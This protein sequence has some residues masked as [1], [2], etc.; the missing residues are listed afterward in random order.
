[1]RVKLIILIL[2][3]SATGAAYSQ[4]IITGKVIDNSTHEPLYGVYVISGHNQVTTTGQD[5][6]FRINAGLGK[7]DIGFRFIGYKS[8]TRSVNIIS[9]DTV[10]LNVGLDMDLM[11]ISQIVVTANRTE[12]KIA[13]LTVSMDV[14]KSTD[15]LKTHI[16]DPEELITKTSGIEVMDG[17]ASIRGGTGFS[18][19]AGSRVLALIDGLPMISPDAGN[20]KWEFLPL[21]NISQIEIIKGASSVLY[22]SSALNGII[23][24][25]TADAD[26]TGNTQFFAEAGVFGN[27]RNQ[28]WKWWS[29]PRIFSSFSASH[30]KKYGKT[31]VGI[32]V[33]LLS[34]EGYRKYNDLKL[35]R[36]G[37]RLKHHNMKIRGLTYGL[38]INSGY[39]A[40]RDFV[41]WEDATHGALKQD[42]ST[43]SLLHGT[44]ISVNPYISY[45]SSGKFSHDLRIRFL[46]SDN[47]FPVRTEN[48]SDAYSVY[49][50]YQMHYRM[51]GFL[52]ITAGLTEN[53]NRILSN[54]YHD[55]SGLNIAGFAQLELIP[56]ARLKL[57][58]GVRAEQYSLDNK[59]DKIVPI[60]RTG[61]NWQVADYTFLR[62]SYGQGYRYPSIAEKFASTTL[63]SVKIYPDPFVK[64]ESGWSTEVGVKQGIAVGETKG[65]ADL[66]VFMSQNINMIEYLFGNYPD[67]VTGIFGYGFMAT[68]IEDARVYGSEIEFSLGRKIG[69]IN[70]T[71]SGGYTYVYP[72]EFN[73]A[74]HKNTGIYLKYR[75]K[76]SALLGLSGAYKRYELGLN[77]FAK[78]KILRID[79]VFLN[80]LTREQILPGFYD[81][82][83]THNTGNFTMDA[84]LGYK[85]SKVF[86]LSL[87]VKNI[88]NT[89]YMGRPGDIQPQRNYS[90]RFA[91]KL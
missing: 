23:N 31:D 58:A 11:E 65:Q 77:L 88:T 67:P 73:P 4:G 91:G 40:K 25:R 81:Y 19:G 43:V 7:S 27:P 9:N 26:T 51:S 2:L 22:G 36:L 62:A 54:F 60:I 33:D 52:N 24:F 44:Y 28:N 8:T 55:H 85:L 78:S 71:L 80:P 42:T 87:V 76:H 45:N 38:N 21:E 37:I 63:G 57:V 29:S 79:D 32:G 30:L 90:I 53:F 72:V 74:T 3:G 12:Q 39:L 84:N 41:L 20:I 89:E 50:E 66:S 69:N 34:D 49:S 5:G 48:N 82:W 46:L 75:R 13:E 47:A 18:Y 64:A 15:F 70:T 56:A 35:M 83:Q 16:T 17:Q 6:R 86:T 10:E 14:L 59:R 1:M 68:N 61:L